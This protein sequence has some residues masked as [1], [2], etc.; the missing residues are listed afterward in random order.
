VSDLFNVSYQDDTF[1]YSIF[2]DAK[3]ASLQNYLDKIIAQKGYRV[4]DI[5][6]IE[7]LL[8]LSMIPYHADHFNRQ[9]MMYIRAPD[10]LSE[11]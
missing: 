4:Y 1:T 2:Q 6:L 5:K 7:G 8:F 10:I 3:D 9:Q 11:L